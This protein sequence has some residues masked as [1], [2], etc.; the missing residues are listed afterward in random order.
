MS[1]LV[2]ISAVVPCVSFGDLSHRGNLLY[3]YSQLDYVLN[4][5]VL[6]TN[7]KLSIHA[8]LWHIMIHDFHP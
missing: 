8:A 4:V 1:L 6:S 3:R 7:F 5:H 2:R